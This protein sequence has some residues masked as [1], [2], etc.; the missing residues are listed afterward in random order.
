MGPWTSST[1][2][3]LAREASRVAAEPVPTV[4][5][6]SWLL[7]C[8]VDDSWIAADT[9]SCPDC[10]LSSGPL[11]ALA[12]M[13]AH[14]LREAGG[15]PPALAEQRVRAASMLVPESEAFLL[16]AGRTL[17]AVGALE[18]A[19]ELLQKAARIAPG[20]TDI[21]EELR[22][23]DAALTPVSPSSP[24]KQMP[25]LAESPRGRLMTQH[26]AA[27]QWRDSS[28]LG[29]PEFRAAALEVSQIE[30]E[31]SALSG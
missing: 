18:A 28:A 29:S 22:R 23:V 3:R 4:V 16:D 17:A 10:G 14:A 6:S 20:R 19:R 30:I 11:Q 8:P 12:S 24:V 13:A 2:S 7:Q 5:T 25:V 31:I 15:L 9:S 21:H 27:R 1:C 26:A